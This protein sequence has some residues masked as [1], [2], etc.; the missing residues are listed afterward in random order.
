MEEP[1]R[2]DICSQRNADFTSSFTGDRGARVLAYLSKYCLEKDCT[3]DPNSGRKS[4]FN[5]G[6]RSV[7][8]EIRHWLD[9]DLTKIEK[10]EKCQTQD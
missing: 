1:T 4:D 6:A 3:F 9:I 7:I 5:Q 10:D 8:L 2:H